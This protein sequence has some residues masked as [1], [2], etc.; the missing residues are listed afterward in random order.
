MMKSLF[1]IVVLA[2]AGCGRSPASLGITGPGA[3]P[4]PDVPDNISPAGVLDGP[5]SPGPSTGP[6]PSNGPYFNYN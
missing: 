1:L 6:M 2:V 3:P 4:T 5:S